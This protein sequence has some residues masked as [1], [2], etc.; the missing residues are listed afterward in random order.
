MVKVL[1]ESSTSC[2]RMLLVLLAS[3]ALRFK[4]LVFSML[5]PTKI[6]DSAGENVATIAVEA[7]ESLPMLIPSSAFIDV[8]EM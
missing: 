3:A 8:I 6:K 7:V 2:C 1:W 4:M 5:A